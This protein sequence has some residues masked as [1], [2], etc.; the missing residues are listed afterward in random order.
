MRLSDLKTGERGIIVKV[1]G[2]GSFRK[3]IT[4]MGFIKGKEVRVVLN[5]PLKDPIEYEIIG[6]KISLR[7]EEAEEIEVISESEVRAQEAAETATAA[8]SGNAGTADAGH[9][10]PQDTIAESNTGS[11]NLNRNETGCGDA[12]ALDRKMRE[13]AE[14]RRHIVRVALVGNPNCGKTSLFNVASGSHEHVGNYSGVTVDAKEGHF[15]YKGYQFVLVDLPGTY[16]LSAYSP[17]EL[18]V[19]KN[20]IENIP[21]VV[22]NV[23]D[24][25]N[26]ERNLYLTAQIIDMNLRVVMA[27]NM[28]DELEAKGDKL[29]T[30]TL[31]HLLG[32][33]VI[34]T[35]SR[36]GKGIDRLFDTVIHVYENND[37]TVARHIHINHGQELETSI[38]RLQHL[39]WKN[40]DIRARY[41]TRWLAIKYLENDSDVE[42]TVEALP[43]HDEISGEDSGGPA[44]P[45]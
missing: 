13:L 37:P 45:R 23:V 28:Y 3:R 35:V 25:S 9:A 42:K 39:I 1:S 6:Y 11:G 21:D 43:N 41:S 22:I 44:Q 12:E 5:A 15:E 18:Y 19:R 27:L 20:L 2:H 30:V 36:S 34:P 24:A 8:V 32:I 14:E 4:E 40:E 26:L 31:G 38:D 29:D 10:T 33:P 17:E 7:R 16:S